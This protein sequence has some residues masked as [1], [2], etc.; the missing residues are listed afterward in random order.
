MTLFLKNTLNQLKIM[1]FSMQK[2]NSPSKLFMK[3]YSSLTAEEGQYR[4]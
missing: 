2:K 4:T 3:S 1:V